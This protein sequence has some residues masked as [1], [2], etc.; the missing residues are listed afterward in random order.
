MQHCFQQRGI[1]SSIE[2]DGFF[3]ILLSVSFQFLLHL[4]NPETQNEPVT[5]SNNQRQAEEKTPNPPLL[6]T[7][8]FTWFL[9]GLF[10]KYH[11]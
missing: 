6:Q 5:F 1:R 9:R 3:Q 10:F 11:P 8:P 4:R 2:R 7:A